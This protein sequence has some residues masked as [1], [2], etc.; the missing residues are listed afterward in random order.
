MR[1]LTPRVTLGLRRNDFAS[2]AAG[3]QN[4]H[5]K[6]GDNPTLFASP[7][8]SLALLGQHVADY[9]EAHLA[10]GSTRAKGASQVRVVKRDVL[11]SSLLGEQAYVQALCDA[12]PE[13]AANYAAAAGMKLWGHR[14]APRQ[15]LELKLTTVPGEVRLKAAAAL[16]QAPGKGKRRQR[17]YLWRSTVDGGKTFVNADPTPVS[18]TLIS[19]LPLHTI[20]GFQVAVKDSSGVSEWSQTVTILVV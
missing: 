7:N 2:L 12:A 14:V 3:A 17:T 10:V 5:T 6:M 1:T 11:W 13:L 4:I 20:V 9:L 16:L 8:P 15:V 19:G 18:H